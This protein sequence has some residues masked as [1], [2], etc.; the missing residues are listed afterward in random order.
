LSRLAG[1]EASARMAA[2]PGPAPRARTRSSATA[3]AASRRLDR[4]G[5]RACAGADRPAARRARAD[6]A[7]PAMLA[8][9]GQALPRCGR[10]IALDAKKS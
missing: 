7:Q 8:Q 2:A 6:A 9:G 3:L 4:K 5:L 10:R 1:G